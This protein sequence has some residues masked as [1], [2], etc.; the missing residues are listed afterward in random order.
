MGLSQTIIAVTIS[1]FLIV[2][3]FIIFISKI[4]SKNLM[5]DKFR[6]II[7]AVY[8][9]VL[10]LSLFTVNI[11][12]KNNFIEIEN[13]YSANN[14]KSNVEDFKQLVIKG[15]LS[16]SRQFVKKGTSNF[17]YNGRQLK[18]AGTADGNVEI[19]V[20]HK[21]DNDGKIEAI[22]YVQKY[23]FR[24]IDV[25]KLLQPLSVKLQG[26]TLFITKNTEKQIRT[27]QFEY[28]LSAVQFVKNGGGQNDFYGTAM[29]ERKI[30]IEIPND[31]QIDSDYNDIEA[32]DAGG[33]KY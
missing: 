1:N 26:D 20:Q 3:L 13:E 9:T 27:K 17:K 10:L 14:L 8:C 4:I 22:D 16:S 18:L 5:S 7:V 21:K 31:V 6:K 2:I 30:L 29:Y 19:L 24:S 25:S 12:P 28:D 33:E 11:L 23:I 32:V 15:K